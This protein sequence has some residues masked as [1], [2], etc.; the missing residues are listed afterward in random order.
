MQEFSRSKRVESL[1]QLEI[2]KIIQ[3]EIDTSE[4]GMITVT[5]VKVTP[6]LSQAKIYIVAHDEE[7]AKKAVLFLNQE[8]KKIR[9]RLSKQV[10][11]RKSPVLHFYYDESV[12][13]GARIDKLLRK[14]HDKK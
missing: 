1:I 5:G 13:E 8:A 12:S 7:N 2:A 10:Q 9:W 6:D 14:F 4:I 11:L 3:F